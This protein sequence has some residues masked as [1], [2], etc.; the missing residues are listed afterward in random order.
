MCIELK[1]NKSGVNKAI[2]NN[3]I[4]KE[5][6]KF[7]YTTEVQ[8]KSG[9]LMEKPEVVNHEPS[10]EIKISLKVQRLDVETINIEYK[11]ST[12]AR[13]EHNMFLMI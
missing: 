13:Q 1:L 4:Y 10:M 12:S 6:Y 8:Y 2:A 11:T 7:E 5:K 3:R 9:E